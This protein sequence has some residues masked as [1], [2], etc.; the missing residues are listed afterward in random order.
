MELHSKGPQCNQDGN[1]IKYSILGSCEEYHRSDK[2]T[3]IGNL[4]SG[5][6]VG[7]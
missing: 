5:F 1:I 4:A 3:K 7:V 6:G 2:L